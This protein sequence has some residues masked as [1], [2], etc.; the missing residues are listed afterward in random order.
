MNLAY[1]VPV[2]IFV[3][4]F[5]AAWLVTRRPVHRKSCPDCGWHFSWSERW[6][7][8]D[9]LGRRKEAPC[10]RCETVLIWS[11]YPWLTMS[12]ASGLF[13]FT[14]LF[15]V[16]GYVEERLFGENF[17]IKLMVHLVSLVLAMVMAAAAHQLRFVKRPASSDC[18]SD[19][20]RTNASANG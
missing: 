19:H 1:L 8:T 16:F 7:F 13:L 18:P 20:P 17:G 6:R 14:N 10:P 9:W 2:L 5:G 4:V 12:V 11:K 15:T 3:V